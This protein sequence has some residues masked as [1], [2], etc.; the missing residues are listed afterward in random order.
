MA[1]PAVEPAPEPARTDRPVLPEGLVF[2]DLYTR[3]AAYFLDGVLIGALMLDPTGRPRSVRLRIDIPARADAPCHLRRYDGLRPGRTGGVLPVVLDGWTARYT[4]ATSLRSAGRQCVRRSAADDDPGRHPLGRHGLVAQSVAAAAPVLRRRYRRLRGKRDLWIV[5]A[6]SVAVSPTK[7]GLHDRI[8]R[9]A[10]VRPAGPTDRWALGCAWLFIGLVVVELILGLLLVSLVNSIQESGLYPPGTNPFD[11]VTEQIG[12][13][14]RTDGPYDGDHA[15]KGRGRSRPDD[16]PRP[17]Q[18]AGDN[19]PD[20]EPTVAWTPPEPDPATPPDQEAQGKRRS[21]RARHRRQRNRRP[22]RPLRT[23]PRNRQL[24]CPTPR[25]TRHRVL[26]RRPT[27]RPIPHRPR[28]VRSSAP[29]RA[30]RRRAGRRRIGRRR[31]LPREP[32]GTCRRPPRPWRRLRTAMSSPAS[33]RASS[34]G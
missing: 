4:G 9:S 17:D 3:F 26:P 23:C 20:N 18:P 15:G 27:H 1:G 8:A 24:P 30:N 11:Y 12:S 19:A 31:P 33:A 7:Q 22:H 5:L 16:R 32:G 13:S 2:A 10:I 25:L 6:I 29:L 28:P 14:G 21:P 34:R